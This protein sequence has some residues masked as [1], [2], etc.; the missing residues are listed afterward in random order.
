[1]KNRIAL[2]GLLLAT[3]GGCLRPKAHLAS[4]NAPI[5]VPI[6]TVILLRV[7]LDSLEDY[8]TF[9]RG[10]TLG[11]L[12][13]RDTTN[14]PLPPPIQI[15]FSKG[16]PDPL[17]STRTRLHSRIVGVRALG[18]ARVVGPRNQDAQVT[19]HLFVVFTSGDTLDTTL[20]ITVPAGQTREITVSQTANVPISPYDFRFDITSNVNPLDPA[21]A[22]T[23][24]AMLEMPLAIH[25]RGDTL[26]TTLQT[27]DLPTDVS[28]AADPARADSLGLRIQRAFL[29]ITVVNRAPLAAF[30]RLWLYNSTRTDSTLVLDDTLHP[31][32]LDNR[33]FVSA[34]AYDTL[35]VELTEALLSRYFA[36]DSLRMIA[37]VQLPPRNDTVYVSAN[38]QIALSGYL[39]F[40]L[41]VNP[42]SL[43]RRVP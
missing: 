38:D 8:N 12:Q 26:V 18:Y 27:V 41:N 19:G 9:Q 30:F 34:P 1:L 39:E 14:V 23:A 35:Q 42:D 20:Q 29:Y 22:D 37:E 28:R 25:Y 17:D 3:L 13:S 5:Q 43:V 2:A 21:F 16:W 6:D 11:I 33:G 7:A 24:Y 4:W 10:D 32:Q 40:I 31:A 36:Q 15:Y